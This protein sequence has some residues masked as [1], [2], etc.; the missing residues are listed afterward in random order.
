MTKPFFSIIIP[1]YNHAKF[2]EKALKSVYAQNFK[3]FEVIVIDNYSKDNTSK[4]VNFYK[5]IVYKKIKNRGMIA[6]SRNVGINLS[7]GKWLAF[8]D[9]DDYWSKDK[10]QVIYNLIKIK[11]FDL[12]C[13]SEWI[14]QSKNKNKKIWSC[15]PFSNFFYKDMLIFGNRSSTS[16]SVVK[17]KFIQDN[18]INFVEKKEFITSED[19]NFFLD[20]AH[21]RGI[22]F[23]LNKPLGYH[24]FYSE[25]ASSNKAK[26]LLSEKSVIKNH[27][28]KIQNFTKNKKSLYKKI[29]KR[30]DFKKKILNI[31]NRNFK[32][33]DT[34]ELVKLLVQE[35][36]IMCRYI[37]YF[38]SKFLRQTVL[39]LIY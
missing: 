13:H 4:V 17:K 20:I 3:N 25:S 16:A 28:N 24:L 26:H 9:A 31:K 19:Y 33:N 22:F 21:K 14:I 30:I 5:N 39:R 37:L 10:L 1:T 23:F 38:V 8:L 29:S 11:K 34:Y 36:G 6:K 7:S 18:Q 27:V 32:I 15:G 2:L 35:P 12:I